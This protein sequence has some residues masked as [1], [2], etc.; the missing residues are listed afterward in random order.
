MQLTRGTVIVAVG[1]STLVLSVGNAL[2]Q[3]EPRSQSSV[4]AVVAHAGA[5]AARVLG[6]T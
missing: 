2:A 4:G 6:T 5:P 3:P 1:I